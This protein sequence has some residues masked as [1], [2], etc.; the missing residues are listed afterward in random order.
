MAIRHFLHH[1]AISLLFERQLKLF[2]WELDTVESPGV[3][4][5]L[6]LG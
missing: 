5:S 2:L 6:P 3:F 1:S 4:A